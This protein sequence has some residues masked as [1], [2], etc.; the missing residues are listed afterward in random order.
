[1]DPDAALEE[2]RRA[3]KAA[4]DAH[5]EPGGGVELQALRDLRD[6]FSA[7]DQWLSKGGYTPLEWTS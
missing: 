6:A 3:L 7:L 5:D 4:E 1:M 2:A